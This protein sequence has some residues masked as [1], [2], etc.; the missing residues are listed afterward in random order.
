MAP[1]RASTSSESKGSPAQGV[2]WCHVVTLSTLDATT[3]LVVAAEWNPKYE[4]DRLPLARHG[5]THEGLTRSRHRPQ[6]PPRTPPMACSK[7]HRFGQLAHL[8]VRPDH[9]QHP[10][11]HAADRW[12]DRA[13]VRG[14]TRSV[15]LHIT[16]PRPVEILL[17]STPTAA[18]GV[19]SAGGVLIRSRETRPTDSAKPGR[20]EVATNPLG[21]LSDRFGG[22]F[23]R[24][25]VN[26]HT[27]SGFELK[28]GYTRYQ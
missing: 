17:R 7:N 27:K 13:Q 2:P 28:V 19:L 11:L 10:V 25:E 12:T 4:G 8:A 23:Q 24:R 9:M 20:P 22:P 26:P 18:R 5:A 16:F 14:R 1:I 6:T 21:V 3:I 15:R